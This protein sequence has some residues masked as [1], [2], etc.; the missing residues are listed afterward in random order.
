MSAIVE[1]GI[2]RRIVKSLLREVHTSMPGRVEDYDHETQTASVQP[3]VSRHLLDKRDRT[4]EYKD[5]SVI[6]NVPIAFPSAGGTSITFPLQRGDRVW[7]FFSESP[8][9]EWIQDTL[10][11]I[12]KPFSRR[13]HHYSDAVAVP[14][15]RPP[16]DSL[17]DSALHPEDMVIN[18]DR[19]R[20]GSANAEHLLAR[21]DKLQNQLEI[22]K[23]EFDGH[24]HNY[25]APVEDSAEKPDEAETTSPDTSFTLTNDLNSETIYVDD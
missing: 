5:H 24:K 21:V 4:H 7:L 25:T 18:G 2:I 8:L 22:L 11:R 1:S 17:D 19:L 6:P 12:V 9:D 14:G 23:D 20:I 13:K 15:V 10:A 16:T 3:L